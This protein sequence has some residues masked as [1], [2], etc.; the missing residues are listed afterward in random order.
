MLRR[1]ATRIVLLLQPSW[2]CTHTIENG[3]DMAMINRGLFSK[4]C[5]MA[6]AAAMWG[7]QSGLVHASQV[8]EYVVEAPFEDVRLDLGDAVINRGYKIAYE[9]FIGDM[10]DRTAEAVGATKRVYKHAE[11]VQFCSAVLSR[12]TMEAD[13][14][15]IAYCP[16]ILFVYERTDEP[17]K[18]HVGFR[19]LDEVGNDASR[20][21]LANVNLLLDEMVLEAVD[22]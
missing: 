18:V 12:A 7:L 9:A 21:A 6:I 13:P 8:T 2:F 14:G 4:P 17:G 11:L 10:L 22:Q 19:R 20:K 3:K 5:A 15:N 16:Y 1:M